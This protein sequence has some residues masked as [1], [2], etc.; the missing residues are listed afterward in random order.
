[1]NQVVLNTDSKLTA[2]KVKEMKSMETTE[3]VKKEIST[4]DEKLKA[5][6]EKRKSKAMLSK[7]FSSAGVI[8]E[9]DTR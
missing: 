1:M 4:Q 6:L 5:K 2:T 9:A 3:K 7:S 8:G